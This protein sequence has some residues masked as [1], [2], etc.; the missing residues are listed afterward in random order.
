MSQK[1]ETLEE[2]SKK[3]EDIIITKNKVTKKQEETNKELQE[4]RK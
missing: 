1:M 3:T 4:I 2:V